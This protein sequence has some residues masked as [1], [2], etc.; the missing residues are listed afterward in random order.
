VLEDLKMG[1]ITLVVRN[2]GEWDGVGFLGEALL[3]GEKELFV[4]SDEV[5]VAV[6]EGV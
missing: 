1:V 6:A 3:D 4:F 2:Q 5:C